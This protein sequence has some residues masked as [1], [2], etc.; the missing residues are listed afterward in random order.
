V[1]LEPY[2]VE[3]IAQGKFMAVIGVIALAV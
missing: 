3:I 2:V 1:L